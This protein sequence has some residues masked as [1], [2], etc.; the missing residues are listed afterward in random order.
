MSTT[1]QGS[2][3][4]SASGTSESETD[5][6]TDASTTEGSSGSGSTSGASTD[7]EDTEDTADLCGNGV[8]DK[9][10]E[11]CDDGNAAFMD[12]CEPD[13]RRTY[14]YLAMGYEHRCVLV[15]DG[16]IRCRGRNEEGQLGYGHAR[17]LGEFGPP[18]Q[19]GGPA[20]RLATGYFHTCAVLEDKTVRC[21][22]KND[23][24][25]LGLGH[26]DTIGDQGGE[27]PPPAVDVGGPVIDIQANGD[28]TCALLESKKVR[29]WGYR[30]NGQG[31]LGDTEFGDEPDEM[32]PED[33]EHLENVSKLALGG[34]DFACALSEAG[35][36]RCWGSN[37][38]G[39]LGDEEKSYRPHPDVVVK[40]DGKVIDIAAGHR[41]VCVVLEGG[42]M[43][44][45]GTNS[46]G[47]LGYGHTEHLGDDPGEMPT[48]IVDIGGPVR[49]L[50]LGAEY[51]CAVLDTGR[52][53]CWGEGGGKLGY[54][55]WEPIGDDEVPADVGDVTKQLDDNIVQIACGLEITCAIYEMGEMS[56]WS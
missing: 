32:P 48:P 20:I 41:H 10:G 34:I 16:S 2:S 50:E 4:P 45:W 39:T 53:R 43:R 54:D 6:E 19:L 15:A 33:I 7:T 21:W 5:A 37:S 30:I 36:V 11:Q 25:Q 51:G 12:G 13:C 55:T 38:L 56:C 22:G 18:V 40:T 42:S 1:E 27:M 44:C 8:I 35:E 26:A 14:Q 23:A 29:C 24:G 46:E 31:I 3:A 49:S 47:A 9:P 28:I 52:A 17:D